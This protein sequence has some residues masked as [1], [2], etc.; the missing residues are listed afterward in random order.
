VIRL[1]VTLFLSPKNANDFFS[2]TTCKLY[3]RIWYQNNNKIR[4]NSVMYT[5]PEVLKIEV[6]IPKFFNLSVGLVAVAL[7]Q[8]YM[9]T[10]ELKS[11]ISNLPKAFFS[12]FYTFKIFFL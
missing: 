11:E 4:L 2:A 6:E 8:T 9:I 5:L 7:L 3:I 12:D 10:M 1:L